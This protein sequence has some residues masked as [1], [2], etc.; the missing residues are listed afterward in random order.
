MIKGIYT[1]A[2]GLA[3]SALRLGV[4]TNNVA[5]ANT[6]GYKQDRIPEEVGRALDLLR[7]ATSADGTAIGSITLGPRSG[8]SELDLAQGALQETSNPLD[9]ALGGRG[10]FA[11][12]GQDGQARYTRD[13]GLNVDALGALRARDGSAVLDINNQ[14]IQVADGQLSVGADGTLFVNGAAGPRLQ[15]VE[16]APAT[17]LRKVGGGMLVPDAGGPAPLPAAD[18][19]VYQGFLENSNVDVAESMTTVMQ[20]TRAYEANQRLLTMQDT[21]LRK[22]VNDVGRV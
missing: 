16:F 11:V 19:Q 18:T 2:A 15:I 7:M 3:T 20:L 17:E 5:N 6:P 10:F 14:P 13:G 4:V 9:L 1:A 12:Q 22:T 8:L 21:T